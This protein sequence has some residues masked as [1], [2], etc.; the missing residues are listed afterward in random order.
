MKY[1]VS[2]NFTVSIDSVTVPLRTGSDLGT[3]LAAGDPSNTCNSGTMIICAATG[4][5]SCANG[6]ET[7]QALNDCGEPIRSLSD[8]S[9]DLVIPNAYKVQ[10]TKEIT[11]IG[12]GVEF[13]E[14]NTIWLVEGQGVVM[15]K[16]EHRWTEQDGVI[17]WKE[18]SRLE[19]KAFSAS[20]NSAMNRI[21]ENNKVI[22]IQDFKNEESFNNDPFIPKPTAIIQ[23][24]RTPYDQ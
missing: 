21:F 11:L 13:G 17:D 19:L 7:D 20:D 15:D 8:C 9:R 23:R 2:K 5:P 4:L 6:S 14:R 12:P 16:L 18:F 22:S 1:T 24:A 3:E 10:R